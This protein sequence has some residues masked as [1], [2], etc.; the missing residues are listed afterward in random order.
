M[1][2]DILLVAALLISLAVSAVLA[3]QLGS[4]RHDRADLTARLDTSTTTEKSALRQLRL[5]SHNLRVIGMSL[6][7]HAEHLEAGGTPDSAG[8]ANAA[9]GVLDAADYM[10]EWAEHAE[11]THVLNEELLSLSAVLDEAIS[12]VARAILPSQRTWQIDP[13]V[14]VVRLR[15]DRRALRHV[16][17]RSLSVVARNSG[18][19]DSIEI[20]REGAELDDAKRAMALVI[21]DQVGPEGRAAS[22]VPGGGPDLRLTLARALMEAH[23]GRL[24]VEQRDS[25]TVRITFPIERIIKASDQVREQPKTEASHRDH[26]DR[27]RDIPVS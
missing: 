27:V 14:H 24:E 5:A 23:G 20:R 15:A 13:D 7:G 3:V 16:L 10:H 8:I 19:D 9:A 21:E 4:R 17:T 6:Q 25:V 18:R 12:T 2:Y 22:T 11:S 26:D 1:T